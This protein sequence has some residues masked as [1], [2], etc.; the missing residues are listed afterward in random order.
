MI[1]LSGAT[2]LLG[3][4][5]LFDLTSKGY[6]V[7]ALYRDKNRI[8]RVRR[9]FSFY[10]PNQWV[11]YWEHIEWFQ[12]DITDVIGLETAFNQV[13]RVIHSAAMV[14]FQNDNFR[15]LAQINKNGTAN[16]VNLSLKHGVSWFCHVS[17]TAAVGKAPGKKNLMINEEAK[18]MSDIPVS[19]YAMSKYLAELEVWRGIEEGLPA[20]I[21]NPCVIL[22]PGDWQETSLTI[23]RAV[24]RG[25]KFYA[26]GSNAVIDVRDVSQRIL[27]LMENQLIDNRFLLIGENLTFKKLMGSIAKGMGKKEPHIAVKSWM[28]GLAWRVAAVFSFFTRKPTALTKDATTSAFSDTSYSTAKFDALFSKPYIKTEDMI[29][30]V[31]RFKIWNSDQ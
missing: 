30:N 18:W 28:M 15:K 19:G 16:I 5:I 14:S 29:D 1:L 7:R 13:D 8:D 4:H 10:A 9:L 11:G 24:D 27:F 25:L 17:S 23:F 31:L 20:V 26:P 22:G 12:A 21:V 3:M 6:R 2:G